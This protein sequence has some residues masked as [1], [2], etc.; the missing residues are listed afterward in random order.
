[1]KSSSS[2]TAERI[3]AGL[4]LSRT[5]S[6]SHSRAEEIASFVAYLAIIISDATGYAGIL[7]ASRQRAGHAR[8]VA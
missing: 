4:N 2:F 6:L 1:M 8:I 7:S 5:L 3:S